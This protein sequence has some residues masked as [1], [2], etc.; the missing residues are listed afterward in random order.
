[1]DLDRIAIALWQMAPWDDRPVPVEHG[2]TNSRSSL[3][4]TPTWPS[5]PDVAPTFQALG[6]SEVG[7]STKIHTLVDTV[8]NP[9]DFFL[10][11]RQAHDLEGADALLPQ[12][13]ADMLLA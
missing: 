5:R 6:R 12:M 8:G 10:T 11:S 2:S 7:L 13:Q 3:A 1:M 9:L 4:V